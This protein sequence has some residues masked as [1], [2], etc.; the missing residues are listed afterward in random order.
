MPSP[1]SRNSAFASLSAATIALVGCWPPLGDVEGGS[2]DAGAAAVGVLEAGPADV[3]TGPDAH[4]TYRE[5]VLA[6]GPLFYWRFGETSGTVLHDASGHG[7]TGTFYDDVTLGAPGAIAGDRDTAIAIH[8]TS[9]F[10]TQSDATEPDPIG[11][12]PYT[13]ELWFSRGAVADPSGELVT[14]QISDANGDEET[15]VG[16]DPGG[17]TV[18]FDRY[19]SGVPTH[20]T[21]A[22]PSGEAFTHLACVYDGSQLILYVDGVR[23]G[24]PAPDVR[25]LPHKA[26][27]WY[28][29]MS[30]RD[31]GIFNGTID[32]LA[33]YPSQ[34][35]D[36][37]IWLHHH[38]GVGP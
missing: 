9:G 31:H 20:V 27:H 35:P 7:N 3:G 22:I 18:T 12:S 8:G 33:Y 16:V 1:S 11:V 14:K 4:V 19:V 34:L 30:Y 32:E 36:A 15:G 13:I 21:A 29:G 26:S 24:D 6:D 25:P 10:T 28:V 37:R 38:V 5:L 23:A 2:A 17:A